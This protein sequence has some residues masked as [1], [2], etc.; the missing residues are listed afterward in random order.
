[1]KK[2]HLPIFFTPLIG[3]LLLMSSTWA[4][5]EFSKTSSEKIYGVKI[6][7]VSS[8]LISL[9]A[10][11]LTLIVFLN[12][13]GGLQGLR[14]QT[15]GVVF[16]ISPEGHIVQQNSNGNSLPIVYTDTSRQH[17]HKIGDIQIIYTNSSYQHVQKVGNITILYKDSSFPEILQVTGNQ[18]GV[19]IHIEK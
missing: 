11:D 10:N 4:K 18:P 19:K 13:T 12:A 1:M 15:Q 17:V 5:T 6:N 16:R 9:K 7:D 3:S 14:M 8:K 2:C